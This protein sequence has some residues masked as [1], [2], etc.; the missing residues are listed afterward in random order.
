MVGSS[1]ATEKQ[2]ES[3]IPQNVK[4]EP[5]IVQI[6]DEKLAIMKSGMDA[7]KKTKIQYAAKYAQTSN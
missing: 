4:K 2:A 6:R 7:N 1:K 3:T 5:T